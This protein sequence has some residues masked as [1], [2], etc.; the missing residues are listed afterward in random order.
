MK[1][2]SCRSGAILARERT[3]AI[4][5]AAPE[6][7]RNLALLPVTCSSAAVSNLPETKAVIARNDVAGPAWDL[8][9]VLSLVVLCVG[10]FLHLDKPFVGYHEWGST[11]WCQSAHNNLRA[12]LSTTL[13]VP[14]GKYCGPLPIPSQGYFVDHP[15]GVP[16]MVTAMFALSGEHEWAARLVPVLCSVATSILLWLLLRSCV[17][18]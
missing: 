14:S 10:L 15:P 16:L 18:A 5:F 13:G 3:M 6:T 9:A 11:I 8:G 2:S 12:G 1:S 7:M 17:N 4:L